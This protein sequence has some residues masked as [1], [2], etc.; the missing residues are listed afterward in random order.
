[1]RVAKVTGT[2]ATKLSKMYVNLIENHSWHYNDD[3]TQVKRKMMSLTYNF[4]SIGLN[5][6]RD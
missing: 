3:L 2:N 4:G 5:N 6:D 1:M